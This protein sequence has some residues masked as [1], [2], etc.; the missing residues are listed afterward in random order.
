MCSHGPLI[1]NLPPRHELSEM[2][3]DARIRTRGGKQHRVRLAVPI[4]HLHCILVIFQVEESI[5]CS[6]NHRGRNSH[7]IGANV[8]HQIY[9][10][11]IHGE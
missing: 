10:T 5:L 1:P 2:Q 3:E 4:H 8:E 9:K 6:P 11:S 7:T